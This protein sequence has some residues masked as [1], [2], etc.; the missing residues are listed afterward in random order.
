MSVY[1]EPEALMEEVK[2]KRFYRTSVPSR[3]TFDVDG[4]V[5]NDLT[6]LT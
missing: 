3:L 2:L 1:L 4:C 5:K 6:A